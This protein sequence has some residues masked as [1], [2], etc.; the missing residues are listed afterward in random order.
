MA[1][2]RA[3]TALAIVLALSIAGL[4]A[5]VLAL[6]YRYADAVSDTATERTGRERAEFALDV[7]KQ[8]NQRQAERVDALQKAVNDACSD[9]GDGLDPGDVLGRLR[10]LAAAHDDPDDAKTVPVERPS[11]EADS[12]GLPRPT[13]SPITVLR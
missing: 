3:V 5:A 2:G 10:R 7:I 6:A 8:D 12:A 1:V 11:L 13:S 4:V 9:L